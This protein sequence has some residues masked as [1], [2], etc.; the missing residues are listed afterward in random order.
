MYLGVLAKALQSQWQS[1]CRIR[2]TAAA[3]FWMVKKKWR[4]LSRFM[5]I[6]RD[7]ITVIDL[8]NLK[9]VNKF[10]RLFNSSSSAR[11]FIRK[12]S[13]KMLFFASILTNSMSSD[14]LL[15]PASRICQR[16]WFIPLSIGYWNIKIIHKLNVDCN[17]DS[18][19]RPKEPIRYAW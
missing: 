18:T 16:N 7:R 14:C 5:V 4:S 1:D 6:I 13:N 12:R 2:T 11:P 15:T 19:Y 9:L 3:Y 10:K 17:E 8:I